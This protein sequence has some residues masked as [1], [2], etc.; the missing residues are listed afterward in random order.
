MTTVLSPSLR[1][2][3]VE[4]VR[5]S[6]RILLKELT[7]FGAVGAIALAI[8]LGVFTWLQPDGALK[9]KAISTVLSTTFA[10]F[11]NR[12][13]SFSHR[14]R[15]S[16]GREASFFFG[17]NLITLIFSEGLIA[18]T[19]YG[20]GYPHASLV[21][22]L[23]NLVSIGISTI[24]RFWAYKRFVFLHPDKVHAH[25]VDLDEELAE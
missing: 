3:L 9:A 24:F 23:V 18:T 15:T 7:A 14:A 19:V 22:S 5:G 21:V 10:Y 17:I 2:R 11:G 4:Q 25:H 12:Y 16:L 13:L 6:W 1:Q 20:F 8:D